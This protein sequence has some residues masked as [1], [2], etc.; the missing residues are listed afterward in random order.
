MKIRFELDKV[1]AFV[2]WEYLR[3]YITQIPFLKVAEKDRKL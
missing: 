3:R 2:G 1:A